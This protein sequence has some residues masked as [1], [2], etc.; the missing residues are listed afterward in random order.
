MLWLPSFKYSAVLHFKKDSAGGDGGVK[1]HIFTFVFFLWFHGKGCQ[2]LLFFFIFTSFGVF[3]FCGFMVNGVSLCRMASVPSH[4][5]VG[6]HTHGRRNLL[7]RG[8]KFLFLSNFMLFLN[9]LLLG[10]A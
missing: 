10:V 2:P 4:L 3:L 8:T 7:D 1:F 6:A 9:I 5:P